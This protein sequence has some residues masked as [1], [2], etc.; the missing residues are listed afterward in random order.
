MSALVERRLAGTPTAQDTPEYWE[1][2]ARDERAFARDYWAT[3]ES[4]AVRLR[5]AETYEARARELRG[6]AR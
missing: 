3:V 1:S 6:G 4:R 5:N 2:L